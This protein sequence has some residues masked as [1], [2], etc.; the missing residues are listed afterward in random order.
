MT[1][2]VTKQQMIAL[3]A[4]TRQ[5]QLGFIDG[6]PE[7]QRSAIGTAQDWAA[8]DFVSHLIFWQE[9]LTQRLDAVKDGRPQPDT[10]DSQTL[11]DATF[12]ATKDHSWD[13][14]TA[15]LNGVFD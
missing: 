2:Q 4:E 9:I 14:V 12:E 3:L 13:Q 1:N 10:S 5:A 11:N 8:K 7:A 15:N 6:L